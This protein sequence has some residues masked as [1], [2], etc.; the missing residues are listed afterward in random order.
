MATTCSLKSNESLMNILGSSDQAS[1]AVSSD[2][3]LTLL[4][5][6]LEAAYS[7]NKTKRTSCYDKL[8]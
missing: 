2:A 5:N 6:P 4:Q 1:Q 7:L 8:F 3:L